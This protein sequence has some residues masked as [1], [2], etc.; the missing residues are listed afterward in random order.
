MPKFLDGCHYN[1]GEIS[2]HFKKDIGFWLVQINGNNF[3]TGQILRNP[4]KVVKGANFGW[5]SSKISRTMNSK[6]P[7][8]FLENLCH[9]L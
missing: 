3:A 2:R 6:L 5:L 8:A 1:E 9:Y 7:N 4:V